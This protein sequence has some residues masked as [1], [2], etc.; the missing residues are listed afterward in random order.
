MVRR[1]FLEV[2]GQRVAA[3]GVVGHAQEQALVSRSHLM[4]REH[5]GSVR[6]ACLP[7]GPQRGLAVV[8]HG[9]EGSDERGD[10][11]GEGVAEA[12]VRDDAHDDAGEVGGQERLAALHG[13]EEGVVQPL[14]AQ[15][16]VHEDVDGVVKLRQL[17]WRQ[18]AQSLGVGRELLV[19]LAPR[20]APRHQQVHA[21]VPLYNF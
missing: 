7:F 9:V 1:A 3:E 8:H 18:G 20:A 2:G 16:R 4:R 12:F 10:V 5:G 21:L 6:E 11:G 19:A 13:L 15:R 17:G 14:R